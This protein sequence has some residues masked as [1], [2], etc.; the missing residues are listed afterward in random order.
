MNG[1]R[2]A[3]ALLAQPLVADA[4]GILEASKQGIEL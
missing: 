3:F 1:L 4:P 2:P